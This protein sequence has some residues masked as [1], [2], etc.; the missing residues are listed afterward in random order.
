L[1]KEHRAWDSV[2]RD[3]EAL[4]S[5]A[6]DCEYMA[7]K[8]LEKLGHEFEKGTEFDKLLCEADV[9]YRRTGKIDIDFA[10]TNCTALLAA[11]SACDAFKKPIVDLLSLKVA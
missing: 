11:K 3:Y 7:P 5:K 1:R 10:S 8:L 2:F 4:L 9:S 6:R